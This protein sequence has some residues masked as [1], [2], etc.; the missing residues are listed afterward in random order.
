MAR[1]ESEI[2]SN[3]GM[4]FDGTPWAASIGGLF[5][6]ADFGQYRKEIWQDATY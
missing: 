1:V 3:M 5:F 6:D 4:V 2:E